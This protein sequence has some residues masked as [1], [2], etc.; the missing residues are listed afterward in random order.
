MI[1]QRFRFPVRPA[2]SVPLSP[3]KAAAR[4]VYAIAMQSLIDKR[5]AGAFARQP[6]PTD[7]GTAARP[8]LQ[9]RF[10]CFIA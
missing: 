2:G 6:G 1:S 5:A 9:S 4:S 7:D 3:A 10:R 8:G